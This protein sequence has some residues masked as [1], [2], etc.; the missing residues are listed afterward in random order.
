[1]NRPLQVVIIMNYVIVQR[2]HKK[3]KRFM[4]FVRPSFVFLM[5]QY[6]DEDDK[7]ELVE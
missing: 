3:E 6:W 7:G 4:F 1:M 2:P 5:S